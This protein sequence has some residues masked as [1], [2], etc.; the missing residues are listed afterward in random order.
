MDIRGGIVPGVLESKKLTGERFKANPFHPNTLM[1]RTGDKA[2][3]SEEGN[4]EFLGRM[5]HQVKIRGYRVELGEIETLLLRHP[6][7]KA[8]LIMTKTD[9]YE[10]PY[11]CAY[12]VFENKEL[13]SAPDTT[14]MLHQWLATFL[15]DYMIPSFF[16]AVD[17]FTLTPNGKID[18]KILP[19]PNGDVLRNEQS[20][21]APRNIFEEQMVLLWEKVL[22]VKPIGIMDNFFMLGG[23]SLKAFVLVS[24]ITQRFG[25]NLPLSDLFK[26]PTIAGLCDHL[27]KQE[28]A[29]DQNVILL[30]QGDCNVP[31]LFMIHGQGG[32]LLL[33]LI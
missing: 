3:W 26:A 25:L 14:Q 19:E 29:L 15:P 8:A 12:V 5:D 22:E 24:Q 10:I 11:L 21:C 32:E 1:Y 30:K 27:Q 20:Y 6:E 33:S 16:I 9:S 28:A 13:N 7:V 31:P 17:E 2:R 23:H 4:L 18:R